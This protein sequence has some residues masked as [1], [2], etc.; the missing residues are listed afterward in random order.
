MRE[1][2]EWLVD[3]KQQRQSVHLLATE[4]RERWTQWK[5]FSEYR[6]WAECCEAELGISA[7]AIRIRRSRAI[8]KSDHTPH[9]K[10]NAEHDPEPVDESTPQAERYARA[11]ELAGTGMSYRAIGPRVGLDE[12]AV[13]RDPT[14]RAARVAADPEAHSVTTK[15]N[16]MVC[17]IESA[18]ELITRVKLDLDALL[19]GYELSTRD[20]R[21]LRQ[22]LTSAME[23]IAE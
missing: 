21:R 10:R 14:V 1:Y 2:A 15:T 20:R 22:V 19:S 12:S 5:P 4:L 3:A 13:R 6:T 18:S 9:V 23:R 11:A 17:R 16:P 8:E 7:N